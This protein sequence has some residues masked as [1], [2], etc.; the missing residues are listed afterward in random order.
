MGGRLRERHGHSI[1]R[2]FDLLA[3][4][5]WSLG[6]PARK[7]RVL[8]TC[9]KSQQ[10]GEMVL[11]RRLG[12]ALMQNHYSRFATADHWHELVV[13]LPTN[14]SVLLFSDPKGTTR[15]ALDDLPAALCR[16]L[17]A[18]GF[19]FASSRTRK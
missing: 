11:K 3:W 15:L 7:G 18:S 17:V 10:L 6:R 2:V 1:R 19:W 13:H 8:M 5:D 9:D 4:G 14:T 16:R 12:T